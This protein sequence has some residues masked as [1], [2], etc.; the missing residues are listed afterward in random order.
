M[1]FIH[2]ITRGAKICAYFIRL[3]P[4]GIFLVDSCVNTFDYMVYKP[5]HISQ[6]FY[7]ILAGGGFFIYL[8]RSLMVYIP[9]SKDISDQH[10]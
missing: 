4:G 6:I 9:K 10:I 7:W 2:H 8:T 3:V 5:N 1:N